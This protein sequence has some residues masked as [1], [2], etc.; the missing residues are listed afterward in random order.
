MDIEVSFR[1]TPGTSWTPTLLAELWPGRWGGCHDLWHKPRPFRVW[2]FTSDESWEDQDDRR[3]EVKRNA[4]SPRLRRKHGDRN[5]DKAHSKGP[6]RHHEDERTRHSQL[7]RR[8]GFLRGSI[9]FYERYEECWWGFAS[10]GRFVLIECSSRR[11][12]QWHP[13]SRG[14]F[15]LDWV[16]DPTCYDPR[17]IFGILGSLY[18]LA[19]PDHRLRIIY[20]LYSSMQ[21]MSIFTH[22]SLLAK[23]VRAR[24]ITRLWGYGRW[25]KCTEWQSDTTCCNGEE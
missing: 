22:L 4:L 23:F 13:R 7:S 18:P 9:H 25:S 17:A 11:W 2:S 14:Y 16:M 24:A 20:T 19:V 1:V 21:M 8:K 10:L 3:N 6:S 5:N 12:R 15:R